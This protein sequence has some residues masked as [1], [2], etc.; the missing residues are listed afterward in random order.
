MTVLEEGGL[1]RVGELSEERLGLGSALV[2]HI[3]VGVEGGAHG[4]GRVPG[5]VAGRN[6]VERDG[7]GRVGAEITAPPT[8]V[9]LGLVDLLRLGTPW[10][11]WMG[12]Y[13]L[14]MEGRV[15]VDVDFGDRV[16][17]TGLVPANVGDV[18]DLNLLTASRADVETTCE[19]FG[20]SCRWWKRMTLDDALRLWLDVALFELV[21]VVKHVAAS[22]ESHDGDGEDR[23]DERWML[24]QDGA[25]DGR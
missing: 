22:V 13:W 2:G 7:H 10:K 6:N 8:M 11:T 9:E 12:R 21:L 19:T 24:V 3:V 18:G 14:G 20:P 4:V 15:D 16:V 5:L 17:E 1:D 25:A 23:K